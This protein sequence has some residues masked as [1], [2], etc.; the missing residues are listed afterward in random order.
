MENEVSLNAGFD[1]HQNSQTRFKTCSTLQSFGLASYE[2]LSLSLSLVTCFNR[3]S[4]AA[5]Y[6][7]ERRTDKFS[8]KECVLIN[9]NCNCNLQYFDVTS[10]PFLAEFNSVIS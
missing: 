10:R 1:F 8:A 3:E 9:L 7:L 4:V 6:Q 2:A 5:L